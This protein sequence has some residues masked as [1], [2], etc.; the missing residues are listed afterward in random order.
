MSR[1]K[2]VKF[3]NMAPDVLL[4]A[5]FETS[6]DGVVEEFAVYVGACSPS[7]SRSS[8]TRLSPGGRRPR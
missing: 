5:I 6:E 7:P 3:C 4:A 1:G 2:F 8:R